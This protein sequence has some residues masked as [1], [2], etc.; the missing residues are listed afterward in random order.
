LDSFAGGGTTGVASYKKW[1]NCIS[2][3]REMGFIKTIKAR[4]LKAE[5]R[6]KGS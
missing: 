2:I 4:Q 6:M 5:R 3:E 1:R